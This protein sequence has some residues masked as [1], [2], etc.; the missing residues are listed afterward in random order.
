M[1][2]VTTKLR[3]IAL[4]M[5]AC[6]VT[7]A[8]SALPAAAGG[9]SAP[10]SH[11]SVALASTASPSSATTTPTGTKTGAWSFAPFTP[12]GSTITRTA[13]HL[14]AKPGE[15]VTDIA[16]LTNYSNTELNFNVY[17]SDAYNTKNLGVFT[18]NPPDA[19]KV[20][21][22]KWIGDPVNVVNLP[23][24]TSDTFRF[25]VTVPSNAAPGDHAGGVVALNLAPPSGTQ[26]GTNLAIQRGE[27]IAVYVRVPGDLHAGVA[28]ADI[29]ATT[30]TPMLGFGS[31]WAKAHFEV[32]NTGNVVLNGHAQL[33]AVDVFGSVVK[34]FAP[35]PIV[36]LIPGQVL[37]VNE[38]KWSGL[39]FA[40][41]V[42]LKLQI[43]TTSVKSSGQA[44]FWV[45]PWLFILLVLL[46]IVALVI[47]W[48]RRRRKR[49]EQQAAIAGGTN[50]PGPASVG[51]PTESAESTPVG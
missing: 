2:K 8:V 29:G 7:I 48:R 30:S 20:G 39:P 24:R 10:Q 9:A 25:T 13:I 47:W 43:V 21:V 5:S 15:T 3:G 6:A 41:P 35:V 42:H 51:S 4:V 44:V 16:V 12:P 27:G 46:V 45:V 1:G 37:A 32:E 40:G 28:A 26:K 49:R 18:L 33:K 23:A 17:G 19:P 50:S 36:A 38:K 22:G 11:G 34:T 31:S 14:I